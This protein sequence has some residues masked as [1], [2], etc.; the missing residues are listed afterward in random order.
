[1]AMGS[2]AFESPLIGHARMR[3]LFRG[4]VE[5][6]AI[7]AK[8]KLRG[9]R[10]VEACWVATAIDLKEGDLTSDAGSSHETSVLEHI[11]AVGRRVA[12]GAVQAGGLR[13]VLKQLDE[14]KAAAFAG[15]AAERMF[16]AAGAA[17]ALKAA[18]GPSVVMA[19]VGAD[20]LT[21]VEWKRLL[22]VIGNEV[23]PMV[24]MAVPGKAEV[25]LEAIAKRSASTPESTVPVIP[26]DAGD[27]VAIY[28]VA[29]ETLVRARAGGGAAAILG[30]AC[31]TDPV[32]LMGTQLV[33]KKICTERWVSGVETHVTALMGKI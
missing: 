26:V 10:G 27:V 23:L 4:L 13:A 5:V 33:R 11:R 9:F 24:V 20:E 31:G 15:S 12:G 19:Y 18:G 30:V 21:A 6:R 22:A 2:K 14:T 32:K 29:Q 16:C 1:M 3:A 7:A 25:D 8:R 17:M 28:R